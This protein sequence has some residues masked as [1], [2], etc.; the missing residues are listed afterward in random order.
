MGFAAILEAIVKRMSGEGRNVATSSDTT[1]FKFLFAQ[2]KLKP[3]RLHVA[4][5]LVIPL[6]ILFSSPQFC[7]LL[8][9]LFV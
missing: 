7:H 8:G 2:V 6:C 1:E 4:Y 9:A 5:P 3:S